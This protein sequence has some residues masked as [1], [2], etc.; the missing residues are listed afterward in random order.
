MCS[1]SSQHATKRVTKANV[2]NPTVPGWQTMVD[3]KPS[4]ISHTAPFCNEAALKR[5]TLDYFN[6]LTGSA[7]KWIISLSVVSQ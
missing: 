2:I 6:G 1:E 3:D 5:D 7:T 4:V